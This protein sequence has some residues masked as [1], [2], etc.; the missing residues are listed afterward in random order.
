ML[1]RLLTRWNHPCSAVEAK[2]IKNEWQP[3]N[4][5]RLTAGSVVNLRKALCTQKFI[6]PQVRRA[7]ELQV[8]SII[9]QQRAESLERR[10]AM[11][12]AWV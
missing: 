5:G 9:Q 4:P 2:E 11:V 8:E 3:D 1:S 12:G 7:A 10:R 6:R